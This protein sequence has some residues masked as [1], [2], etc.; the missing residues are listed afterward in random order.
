MHCMTQRWSKEFARQY[1]HAVMCLA[2]HIF[3]SQPGRGVG[4]LA[5][6]TSALPSHMCTRRRL[7][8]IE[9]VPAINRKHTWTKD[10]KT[11]FEPQ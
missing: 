5:G 6:A 7:C 3:L 10:Q 11:M 9:D 8:L 1:M 2:V 4:V